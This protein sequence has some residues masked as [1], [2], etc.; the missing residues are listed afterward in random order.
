MTSSDLPGVFPSQR[1]GIYEGGSSSVTHHHFVDAGVMSNS[2][3]HIAI[4]AGRTHVIS[5]E[6]LP[7]DSNNELRPAQRGNLEA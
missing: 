7:R 3:I 6:V 4:D 1:I 5:L 2:P